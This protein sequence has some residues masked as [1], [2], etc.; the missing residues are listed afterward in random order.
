M[1][2]SDVKGRLLAA[3][4]ELLAEVG[5]AA[6]S[7]RELARRAGVS[8]AAPYNHFEN[9]QALLVEVATDGWARLERSMADAQAVTPREPFAQL[10]ATGLGYLLFALREPATYKLMLQKEYRPHHDE[11]DLSGKSRPAY[12]RLETA[13]R[14]VRGVSGLPVDD[15]SVGADC[16]VCWGLV[17]GLASLAIDA[18]VPGLPH[19]DLTMYRLLLDRLGDMWRGAPKRGG[20]KPPPDAPP[21]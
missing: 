6:V 15:R 17:H 3:A 8:H 10:S 12:H 16:L 5:P 20:A 19:D 1:S 11:D 4:A 18:R 9:K 2:D 21:P 7:L 14:E 13:V